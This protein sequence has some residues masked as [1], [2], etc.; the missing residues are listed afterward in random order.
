MV[1]PALITPAAVVHLITVLKVAKNG[2]GV[3]HDLSVMLSISIAK[4]RGHLAVITLL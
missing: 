4:S 3:A 1:T 2:A